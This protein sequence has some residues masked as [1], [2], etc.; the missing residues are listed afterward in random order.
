MTYVSDDWSWNNFQVDQ[1]YADQNVAYQY[2]PCD[3]ANN[4]WTK[5]IG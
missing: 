4:Q 3:F 1:I 2:Q 5:L